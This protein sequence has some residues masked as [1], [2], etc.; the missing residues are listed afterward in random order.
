MSR[1]GLL[2]HSTCQ[3]HLTQAANESRPCAVEPQLAN[4]PPEPVI[5]SLRHL[6]KPDITGLDTESAEWAGLLRF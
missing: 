5:A 1:L 2:T 6:W 4:Q 3:V